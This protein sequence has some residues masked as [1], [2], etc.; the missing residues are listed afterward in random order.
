[1]KLVILS[2]V[3]IS[4]VRDGREICHIFLGMCGSGDACVGVCQVLREEK[5]RAVGQLVLLRRVK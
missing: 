4:G 5:E 2:G 1:M 3:M